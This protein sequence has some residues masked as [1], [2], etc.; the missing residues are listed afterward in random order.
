[1]SEHERWNDIRSAVPNSEINTFSNDDHVTTRVDVTTGRQITAWKV[2]DDDRNAALQVALLHTVIADL[3]K[4][5]EQN[6]KRI[7]EQG[8]HIRRLVETTRVER[9]VAK[10]KIDELTKSLNDSVHH[11]EELRKATD[12]GSE[13]MTHEDALASIVHNSNAVADFEQARDAYL[14]AAERKKHEQ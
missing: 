13:S 1:M 5:V 3:T 6:N 4:T 10:D 12:G 9:G 2:E 11:Y 8:N 14:A 7:Y